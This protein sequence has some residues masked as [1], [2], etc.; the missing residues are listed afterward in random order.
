MLGKRLPSASESYEIL[1]LRNG[2][3]QIAMVMENECR[4]AG[5]PLSAAAL[6][7]FEQ[8][9]RGMATAQLGIFGTQSVKVVRERIRPDGSM[10][11]SEFLSI[12]GGASGARMIGLSPIRDAGPRCEAAG[13]LL[14]RPACQVIGTLLRG[15]LDEL[16]ASPLELLTDETWSR[17]LQPH[18]ALL[19]SAIR[20]VASLQAGGDPAPRAATLERLIGETQRQA[21]AAAAGMPR[22]PDLDAGGIDVLLARLRALGTVDGDFLAVRALARHLRSAGSP[23]PK[24]EMLLDLLVPGA[25]TAGV[26]L[27]DRF[28][29][30]LVDAP[31]VVRDLLGSQPDLGTALIAACRF[32]TGVAPDGRGDAADLT[33]RLTGPLAAGLLPDTRDALWDRVAGGL[34][35]NRPLASELHAEW[36]LLKRLDKELLVLAPDSRRTRLAAAVAARK[37]ALRRAA[38][39][40]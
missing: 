29:A 13:D 8:Q 39:H 25:S 31:S 4:R 21:R 35:S 40:S 1:A 9:V 34:L 12:N 26:A 14:Q 33:H 10:T 3:W 22:L 38:D 18:E 6:E 17:R 28:L 36:P 15:L 23:L 2:H 20:K 24:I 37:L 5:R 16:G 27:V 19:A 30:G 32:A 11:V 7:A